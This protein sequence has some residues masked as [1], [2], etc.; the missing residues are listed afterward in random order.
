MTN[1]AGRTEE[2]ADIRYRRERGP[3][4]D[5]T[6]TVR[7]RNS[8]EDVAVMADDDGFGS[9]DESFLGRDGNAVGFETLENTVD[10]VEMDPDKLSDAG[11]L[12]YRFV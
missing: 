9:G 1:D 8:A 4:F 2:G 12:G 7:I 11:I 10:V 6:N 3:C 5:D